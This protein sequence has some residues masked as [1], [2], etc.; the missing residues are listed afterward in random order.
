MRDRPFLLDSLTPLEPMAQTLDLK[1]CYLFRTN[2]LSGTS[3]TGGN[4]LLDA[5]HFCCGTPWLRACHLDDAAR[6]LF[7]ADVKREQ[8]RTFAELLRAFE[9]NHLPF[10][11]HKDKTAK[12]SVEA[13]LNQK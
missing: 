4:C 1:G 7:G 8:S 5:V 9:A 12:Q 10:E 13:L 3:L 2:A 11:V 6:M